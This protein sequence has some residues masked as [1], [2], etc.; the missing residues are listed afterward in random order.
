MIDKGHFLT[1]HKMKVF[2]DDKLEKTI[3]SHDFKYILKT[4]AEIR[5]EYYPHYKS[6]NVG[7]GIL[8]DNSKRPKVEFKIVSSNVTKTKKPRYMV[9]SN[10]PEWVENY[11]VNSEND[12][13]A[14]NDDYSKIVRLR[15]SN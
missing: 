12:Y 10:L 3:K 8:L 1:R 11:G 13:Y 6:D 9:F 14:A 15:Q 5:K 2:V 4:K 7:R